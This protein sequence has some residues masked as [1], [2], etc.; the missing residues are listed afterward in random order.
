MLLES[1][2][3]KICIFLYVRKYYFLN[4]FFM[5][6]NEMVKLWKHGFFI[7]FLTFS[8]IIGCIP[9]F[10]LYRISHFLLIYLMLVILCPE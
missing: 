1:K 2:C 10:M 9:T 7:I 5:T 8:F 6:M 4:D 3:V